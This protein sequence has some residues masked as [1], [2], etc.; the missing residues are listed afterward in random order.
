[1]V[2]YTETEIRTAWPAS[3]TTAD[4]SDADA[5]KLVTVLEFQVL[6]VEFY[7]FYWWN[8]AHVR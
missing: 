1:M 7:Q 4:R 5:E 2:G 3:L 6:S 8:C